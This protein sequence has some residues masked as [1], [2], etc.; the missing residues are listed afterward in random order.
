[1]TPKQAAEELELSLSRIHKLCQAKRLGYTEPKHGGS[2]VITEHEIAR[3][4][5]VGPKRP[6]RPKKKS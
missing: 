1:M 3:F 2:W 6:G 5:T 4:R